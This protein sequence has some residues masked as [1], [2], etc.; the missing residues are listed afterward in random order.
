MASSNMNITNLGPGVPRTGTPKGEGNGVPPCPTGDR[1]EIGQGVEIDPCLRAVK[2][3]QFPSKETASSPEGD[4][5]V[6]RELPRPEAPL[7]GSDMIGQPVGNGG[8]VATSAE[9]EAVREPGVIAPQGETLNDGTDPRIELSW[10]FGTP[11]G[12]GDV[13]PPPRGTS[14][15]SQSSRVPADERE[16]AGIMQEIWEDRLTHGHELGNILADRRTEV[17]EIHMQIALNVA[18]E[19]AKNVEMRAQDQM[20]AY[21]RGY[22]LS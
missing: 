7:P 19:K 9:R 13:A 5:H 11:V 16:A 8:V 2:G 21:I 6:L 12:D 3:L 18:R 14:I 22:L 4:R 20:D 10:Q 1:S 17:F 15:D